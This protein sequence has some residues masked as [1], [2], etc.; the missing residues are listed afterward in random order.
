MSDNGE[1]DDEDRMN[2]LIEIVGW[3]IVAGIFA[4]EFIIS[5]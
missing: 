1:H 5:K 2:I 4:L 3:L